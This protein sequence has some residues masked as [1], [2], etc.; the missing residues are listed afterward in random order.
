MSA[1]TLIREAETDGL[2]LTVTDAGTL[3]CTGPKPIA[4]R[5][6]PVL[7]EHKA[8]I[9]AELI[10]ANDPQNTDDAAAF[11]AT[12]TARVDE[13][14]QLIHQLCDLR[15]DED[16]HRAALLEQRKR[17]APE[18]LDSDIRYLRAQIAKRKREQGGT[19]RNADRGNPRARLTRYRAILGE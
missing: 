1:A 19:S 13:C 11:W 7:R 18:K 15:N 12:L 5:W 9:M 17:M 4:E 2:R 16:E 14:D 10:A 8:E 3:K 6:A